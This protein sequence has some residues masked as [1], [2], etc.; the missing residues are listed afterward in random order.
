MLSIGR[1]LTVIDDVEREQE[2]IVWVIYHGQEPFTFLQ[3]FR[4]VH[5]FIWPT[6]YSARC[7]FSHVG[8]H[9]TFF[10]SRSEVN[11]ILSEQE[12]ENGAGMFS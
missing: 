10:S 2:D 11:Y 4:L 7:C 12:I 6:F 8:H 3:N 5:I 1:T 9:G